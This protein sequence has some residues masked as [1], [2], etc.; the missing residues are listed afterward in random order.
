MSLIPEELSHGTSPSVY[1]NAVTN[2]L[3]TATDV[4]RSET[5]RKYEA[6]VVE[7]KV[8]SDGNRIRFIISELLPNTDGQLRNNPVPM[9]RQYIDARGIKHT[10]RGTHNNNFTATYYSTDT[11]RKTAPD[12]QRGERVLVWRKGLSNL[13]YWE[14][15]NGD[16][17]SK[18]RLETVL[19]SVNADKQKG[20]DPEK[21]EGG[22]DGNTYYQEMSSQNKT[23]TIKTSKA[24]G[25]VAAYTIQINA[26]D[27]A[28]ILCDD[29]GNFIELDTVNKKIWMKNSVD[30]MVKLEKNNIDLF[31]HEHYTANI[32]GNATVNIK[33]NSSVTINGNSDISINGNSSLKVNGNVSANVGGSANIDVGGSA[34]LKAPTTKIDSTVTITKDVMI[35]GGL[36]VSGGTS[37]GGGG[38]AT[39]S[40]SINGSLSASSANLPGSNNING[41][42]R[43]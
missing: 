30:T 13:W 11:F 38:T 35:Q 27:G 41:Y 3:N 18:R 1:A 39:G 25:E 9:K 19:Q 37:M 12:V 23:Y 32:G 43:G 7:N 33:G 17:M 16:S 36:T 24:N 26:G 22:A 42:R 28:I 29:V 31:C 4:N 40:F 10:S 2:R 34:S 5:T 6:V 21:H 14:P 8:H 15:F 20:G